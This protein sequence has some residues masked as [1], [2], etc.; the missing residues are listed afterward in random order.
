M[1]K[2]QYKNK[3]SAYCPKCYEEWK[4]EKITTMT[5]E[6]FEIDI[7]LVSCTECGE[8]CDSQSYIE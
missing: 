1:S 2:R 3:P 7:H 8:V 5:S 4:S 6:G